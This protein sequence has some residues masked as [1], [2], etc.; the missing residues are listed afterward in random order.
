[1]H[2]N[3]PDANSLIRRALDVAV[4]LMIQAQCALQMF[5]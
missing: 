5:Y 3:D 1:M 4:Q 2:A